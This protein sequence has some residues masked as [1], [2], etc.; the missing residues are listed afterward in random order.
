MR[1]NLVQTYEFWLAGG[2]IFALVDPVSV[3]R[4]EN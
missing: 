3:W 4:H 1:I 2:M